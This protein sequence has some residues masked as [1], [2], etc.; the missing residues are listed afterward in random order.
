MRTYAQSHLLFNLI[1]D[2]AIAQVMDGLIHSPE[3]DLYD[4]WEAQ[5]Y[6]K[7]TPY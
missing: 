7:E 6:T 5:L 4:I 1:A 3:M 2:A